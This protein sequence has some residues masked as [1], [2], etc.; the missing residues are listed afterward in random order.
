MFVVGDVGCLNHLNCDVIFIVL[1]LPYRRDSVQ[2][3]YIQM[4]CT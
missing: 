1:L 2:D 4:Q 3:K